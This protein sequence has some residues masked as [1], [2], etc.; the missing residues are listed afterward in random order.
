MMC[1]LSYVESG[2]IHETL[3]LIKPGRTVYRAYD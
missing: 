3:V 1:P 2:L